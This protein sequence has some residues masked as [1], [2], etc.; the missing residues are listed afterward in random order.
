MA[1]NNNTAMKSKSRFHMRDRRIADSEVLTE[2]LRSACLKLRDPLIGSGLSKYPLFARGN[3]FIDSLPKP[4]RVKTRVKTH[5]NILYLDPNDAL[6]LSI[7]GTWEITETRLIKNLVKKGDVALD[8]GA[9]IGYYTLLLAKLVGKSGEVIGFEPD[10]DNFQLLKKNVMVNG[11]ANT[12][13]ESKAV[14]NAV[15]A[16]TLYRSALS[17]GKGK[18][19]NSDNCEPIQVD[20]VTLDSYFAGYERDIDFIKMDAE[21]AEACILQGADSVLRKNPNVKIITEFYPTMITSCGDDPGE[22][23]HTLSAYGF[24]FY[25]IDEKKKRV[26]PIDTRTILKTYSTELTNLLCVR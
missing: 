22:F 18:L 24:S 7:N 11:Y 17:S 23:L 5:G 13:L 16:V 26:M 3:A 12:I 10:P 14:S 9:H 25:D 15:G 4:S 19:H 21:G 6:H 1:R 8:I 2:L 20:A